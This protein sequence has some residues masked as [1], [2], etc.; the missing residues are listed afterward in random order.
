MQQ[1]VST[2]LERSE[3][4]VRNA[5]SELFVDLTHF[6]ADIAA[7]YDARTCTQPAIE[8]AELGRR[9]AGHDRILTALLQEQVAEA[10]SLVF[11]I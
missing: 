8:V 6:S 9:L 4:A 7:K 10:S 3:Y 1:R 2:T 11:A 5:L